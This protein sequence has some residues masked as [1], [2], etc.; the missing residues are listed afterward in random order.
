M[1]THSLTSHPTRYAEVVFASMAVWN[2]SFTRDGANKHTHGL[3]Y[4]LAEECVA[5]LGRITRESIK[6]VVGCVVVVFVVFVK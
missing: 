4:R 2:S 6:E 1:H 3:D 5:R